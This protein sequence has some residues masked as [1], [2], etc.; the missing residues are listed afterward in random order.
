MW[1]IDGLQVLIAIDPDG[2][3]GAGGEEREQD[4]EQ[5]V[6]HR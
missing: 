5:K 6:S 4:A 2:V 3:M 1:W